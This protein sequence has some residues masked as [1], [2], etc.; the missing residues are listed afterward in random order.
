MDGSDHLLRA[1]R[2]LLESTARSSGEAFF[3][4][5]ASGIAASL[6]MKYGMVG[7]LQPGGT[8]MRSLALWAGGKWLD[9]FEYDL[10][11]T[12]CANVM[13]RETCFHRRDARALFP[14]D[15]LLV[16]LGIE[17][18]FGIPIPGAEGAP[19]GIVLAMDDTPSEDQVDEQ[20]Q[21]IF[22][23][24][25]Q[26]AA[27]ELERLDADARVRASEA[28]F[29]QIV[30]ACLEGV[31]VIDAEARTTFV[32]ERM[33]S[34][35]GYSADEMLGRTMYDF[36]SPDLRGVAEA[37]MARRQRGVAEQHEFRFRHK[38]GSDVWTILSTSPLRDAAGHVHGALAMATDVTEKR[39]LEHKIQHTQKLESLGVLASGIAHDFN[40]LLVGILA[41]SGYVLK[42]LPTGTPL[43]PAMEDVQ[44][45]AARAAE[46][47]RQLL[48]Y[49]GKGRFFTEPLDLNRVV[50]E[51]SNLL[52]SVIS[53]RA[54][55]QFTLAESMP[56][57]SADSAQLRQVV[58]N[59]ITNA[60]DALGGRDGVISL[61]T[62]VVDATRTYLQTTYLDEH[63][64][65]GRYVALE[66]ADSGCGMDESTRNK[67]FDPFF[68]TKLTGRG[69][70]L[71]AV[72]GILRGH[73]GAVKVDST[74][75]KGTTFTILLPCLEQPAPVAV[76]GE[77]SRPME[78]WRGTGTVLVAD[79]EDLVRR[80]A[81]RVLDMAGF[82]VVGARDGAE[83]IE[84]FGKHRERVVAV[85]LDMT[86]PGMSGAEVMRGIRALKPDVYV[87][88]SSGYEP[89]SLDQLLGE[90]RVSF[91]RKPWSPAELVAALR[92]A[93]IGRV[94]RP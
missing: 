22:E 94:A 77:G 54:T 36:M 7:V 52:A 18:Y 26:R 74:P 87:L 28:R 16:D 67:I 58:M 27:M 55:L 90:D 75:G 80:V 6:G 2:I 85:V 92:S 57:I 5:L 89:E 24:F 73:R 72:L 41:N 37:N 11:G 34:M 66:V 48:E 79:D 86:M 69:L 63:L 20:L 45:A 42:H 76:V 14:R 84:Q 29:R 61:T 78:T 25:A 40:N 30:T 43:R 13:S 64:P 93:G 53:K 59:L 88:L 39:A 9:N 31:W 56:A 65:E 8:L 44:T 68:T 35:F 21:P 50:R 33:A 10:A 32:N 51:I 47:T 12:P 62:S 60:S 15:K 3:R 46:L 4:G 38:D 1:T 71:A 23:L 70:G 82:A 91:L 81:T 17:S 19:V 83:A 49:S